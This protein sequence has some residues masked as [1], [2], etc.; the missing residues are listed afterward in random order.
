MSQEVLAREMDG[1]DQLFEKMS[2]DVNELE[3]IKEASSHINAEE[4]EKGDNSTPDEIDNEEGHRN[5]GFQEGDGQE[6]TEV[7]LDNDK[8]AEIEVVEAEIEEVERE[9]EDQPLLVVDEEK[10]P[11]VEEEFQAEIMPE[12]EEA[13]LSRIEQE[14]VGDRDDDDDESTAEI[15]EE[16]RRLRFKDEAA[17]PFIRF[18]SRGLRHYKK[19]LRAFKGLDHRFTNFSRV[20]L[21]AHKA[22]WEGNLEALQQIF[23]WKHS[24]TKGAG[25]PCIDRRGATPLHLAARRNQEAIIRYALILGLK[26]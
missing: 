10:E 22:A 18:N 13:T 3:L 21:P 15:V 9:G 25:V 26:H 11:T 6:E 17:T 24:T 4:V 20:D 1:I 12:P 8:T 7:D 14:S 16:L 19:Q 2:A 23:L 5:F